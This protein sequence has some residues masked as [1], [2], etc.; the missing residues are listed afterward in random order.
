MTDHPHCLPTSA[1]AAPRELRSRAARMRQ[2]ADFRHVRGQLLDAVGQ[3]DRLLDR[4]QAAGADA[5]CRTWAHA[6]A[7]R[8]DELL[9]T[10]FADEEHRRFT[11]L[12]RQADAAAQQAVARLRLD[13]AWITANWWD[14]RP[15]LDSLARGYCWV[16]TDTLRDAADLFTTLVREHVAQEADLLDRTASLHS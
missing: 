8:F 14:L 12:Q 7:A 15:M 13:H 11:R 2:D 6:V 10:G 16:D 4:V 3:L 1:V 9:D 5:P